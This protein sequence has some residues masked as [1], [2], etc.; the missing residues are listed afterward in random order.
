MLRHIVAG[1]CILAAAVL[2]M[3]CTAAAQCMS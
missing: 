1:C 2:L 3:P